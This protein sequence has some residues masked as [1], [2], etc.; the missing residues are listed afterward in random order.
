VRDSELR[1]T[2]ILPVMTVSEANG[3]DHWRKKASRTKR[4]RTAARAMCPVVPLPCTVLL[5][6]MSSRELDDDNLRGALKAVRDGVADALGVDDR[7]NRVTWLYAQEK[8]K[9]LRGVVRLDL[10]TDGEP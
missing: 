2:V 10:S 3:R 9:V 1:G 8:H 7:D 6:R 5:T 4:H